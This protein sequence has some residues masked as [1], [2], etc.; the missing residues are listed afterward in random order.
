[1]DGE[2][3]PTH[4]HSTI[5]LAKKEAERLS[6]LFGKKTYV[7]KTVISVEPMPKTITKELIDPTTE[8]DL[9]F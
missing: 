4:Q 2:G 3:A 6:I 9:P 1:M 7:L 5:I 8:D